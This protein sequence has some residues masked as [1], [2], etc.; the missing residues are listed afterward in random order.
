MHTKA[1]GGL[2]AHRSAAAKYLGPLFVRGGAMREMQN[3][4]SSGIRS[5][6]SLL[7]KVALA[8]ALFFLVAQTGF[9]QQQ[10]SVGYYT[11]W[12]NP[13]LPP[14]AIEWGGVTHVIYW[15]GIVHADGTLDLSTQLV[16]TD[17]PTLISAAH[18]HGVKVLLGLMQANWIT[19]DSN[20]LQPAIT[21]NLSTLVTNVMS[22]VN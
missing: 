1:R 7:V 17:G 8:F 20:T 16:T 10:W 19:G 14:T 3:L 5:K 18:A 22:V 21:N 12:G 15:G 6:C 9:A 4:G 2:S 11:P 13:S